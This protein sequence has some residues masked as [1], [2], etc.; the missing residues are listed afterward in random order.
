[1]ASLTRIGTKV[2]EV[3]LVTLCG[4]GAKDPLTQASAHDDDPNVAAST[5][6]MHRNKRAIAAQARRASSA[7]SRAHFSANNEACFSGV[8]FEDVVVVCS[9]CFPFFCLPRPRVV[10][11]AL[12][13]PL[14]VVIVSNTTPPSCG[15]PDP[16]EKHREPTSTIVRA[17]ASA[18]R[19][20]SSIAPF[21]ASRSLKS[22]HP[23]IA[24]SSCFAAFAS[25]AFSYA[26]R[27]SVSSSS[28]VVSSIASQSSFSVGA[29]F[30]A[31]RSASASALALRCASLCDALAAVRSICA[32]A[33]CAASMASVG[34]S[35]R[36]W[37]RNF[38][39]L[40]ASR[41]SFSALASAPSA[42]SEANPPPPSPSFFRAPFSFSFEL[43]LSSLAENSVCLMRPAR[44]PATSRS[45][46]VA[47]ASL[48]RS[49]N[50]DK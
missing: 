11:V 9:G 47:H 7:S 36:S 8:S 44:I 29:P 25:F 17:A 41:V 13:R 23:W 5:T 46:Y 49:S 26:I 45:A 31:F 20:V 21:A 48:A 42:R 43:S 3:V 12:P 16:R 10:V 14:V 4:P 30:R 18:S 35:A 2:S 19:A 40:S 37:G 28:C 15:S 22:P 27:A 34:A 32:S 33:L 50:V 39:L 24:A 1:M 6:R 38:K